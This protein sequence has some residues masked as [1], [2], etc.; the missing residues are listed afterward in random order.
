MEQD[1]VTPPIEQAPKPGSEMTGQ[2]L[3]PDEAAAALAFATNI[4]EGMMPQAPM[5][6]Q[7]QMGEPAPEQPTEEIAEQ[8]QELEE[9]EDEPE[10][11]IEEKLDTFKKD[12]EAMVKK[13]ISGIKDLIKEALNEEEDTK[14]NTK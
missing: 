4:S 1:L 11:D 9:I 6:E 5:D 3:T 2:E 14:K 7:S 10:I 13:E 8:P 12:V